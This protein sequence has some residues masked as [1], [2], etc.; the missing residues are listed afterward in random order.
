M[1][2]KIEYFIN[3]MLTYYSKEAYL[4]R[5]KDYS[6]DKEYLIVRNDSIEIT[7]QNKNGTIKKLAFKKPLSALIQSLIDLLD[8]VLQQD[9]GLEIL[10]E[11]DEA[12]EEEQK[13]VINMYLESLKNRNSQI[14]EEIK[15]DEHLAKLNDE[16]NHMTEILMEE[17]KREAINI[18]P[19]RKQRR[20]NEKI[21]NQL[22][23][24][25]SIKEENDKLEEEQ[26]SEEEK[27]DE[28]N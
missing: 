12:T 27:T 5:E 8:G 16:I 9:S 20:F 3:P 25:Q 18:N 2:D 15:N 6:N 1:G 23:K 14:Q 7:F 10:P 19:N 28:T 21:I 26:K 4:S 17:D 24:I 11:F 13:E 22:K